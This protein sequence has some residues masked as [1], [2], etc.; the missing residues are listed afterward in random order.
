MDAVP[1]LLLLAAQRLPLVVLRHTGV[2][3]SHA[4]PLGGRG[5]FP[6]RGAACGGGG[7]EVLPLSVVVLFLF[8]YLPGL[9]IGRPRWLA[10]GAPW[11]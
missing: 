8:S 3:L 6:G 7:A 1:L 10:A 4:A 2:E 11:P 5:V 9:P